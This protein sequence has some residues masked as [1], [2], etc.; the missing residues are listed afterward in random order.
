LYSWHGALYCTLQ[1][2]L[3]VRRAAFKV[4]NVA[5]FAYGPRPLDQKTYLSL[6]A[7]LQLVISRRPTS[8]NSLP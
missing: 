7:G 6:S 1:P 5:S 4:I 8:I 3:R 2:I